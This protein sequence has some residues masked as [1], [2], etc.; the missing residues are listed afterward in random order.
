M[1]E[2]LIHQL[3]DTSRQGGESSSGTYG[4]VV[5]TV[6]LT[7]STEN[8]LISARLV[9]NYA[10]VATGSSKNYPD[11]PFCFMNSSSKPTVGD[12]SL[13]ISVPSW[14]LTSSKMM[15]R[16]SVYTEQLNVY[17]VK[18]VGLKYID[19]ETLIIEI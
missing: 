14:L 3:V 18:S 6:K 17:G 9:F 13:D 16:V 10:G 4:A 11:E 15:N 12:E 5:V 2:G 8:K 7:S 1:A 19:P